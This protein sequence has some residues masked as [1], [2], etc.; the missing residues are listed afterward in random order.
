MLWLSGE[1]IFV[2]GS[3]IIKHATL[4]DETICSFDWVSKWYVQVKKKSLNRV[5]LYDFKYSVVYIGKWCQGN[6][7]NISG[8]NRTNFQ[9]LLGDVLIVD[10]L[11]TVDER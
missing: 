9:N 2:S 6:Q 11:P 8:W 4:L 1:L 5:G 3:N 10:I 7:D